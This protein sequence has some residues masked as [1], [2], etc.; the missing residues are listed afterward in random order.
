MEMVS[1]NF[2][3]SSTDSTFEKGDILVSRRLGPQIFSHF[4][5]QRNE[6]L[7]VFIQV[8]LVHP[9][10]VPSSTPQVCGIQNVLKDTC[11]DYDNTL[12]D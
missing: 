9:L 7:P 6:S 1:R 3:K 5:R 4:W 11:K 10:K 12:E 8:T 2:G